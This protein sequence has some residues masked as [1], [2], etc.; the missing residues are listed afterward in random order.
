MR[1]PAGATSNLVPQPSVLLRP[2]SSIALRACSRT[3]SSS[4]G[5]LE[6]ARS[7]KR[8]GSASSAKR[9]QLAGREIAGGAEEHEDGVG[10]RALGG[11]VGA[12]SHS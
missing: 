8:P 12:Q 6:T 4:S 3:S 1:I 2:N 10:R 9:E 11:G 7:L 5:R